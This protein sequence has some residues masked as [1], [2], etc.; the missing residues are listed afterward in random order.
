MS[1]FEKLKKELTSLYGKI[2]QT[3]EDK[4]MIKQLRDNYEAE[5]KETCDLIQER[6][7][8]LEI[9]YIKSSHKL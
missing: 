6:Y 4:Q 1:N 3:G 8:Q 7:M 9:D 5:C 2:I